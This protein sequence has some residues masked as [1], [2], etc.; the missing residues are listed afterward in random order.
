M[1][2][3]IIK[4]NWFIFI[5]IYRFSLLCHSKY[6]S[7]YIYR[8]GLERTVHQFHQFPLGT[9]QQIKHEPHGTYWSS[10]SERVNRKNSLE[11]EKYIKW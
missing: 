3:A 2:H 5:I 10:D 11:T 4:Y 9:N 8:S 1:D 6:N 7:K